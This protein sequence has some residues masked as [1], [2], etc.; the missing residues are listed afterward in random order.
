MAQ[1]AL[2]LA[3]LGVAT[4]LTVVHWSGGTPLCIGSAGCGVV[5]ASSYA[6]L[7]AVP[8]ALLGA[9][10]Y[11]ALG[12]LGI[13]ALFTARLRQTA[14][15]ASFTLA[16][17]G[18]LYSAYLTYVEVAVLRAICL[19]CVVSAG[20]LVALLAVTSVGLVASRAR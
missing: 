5:A 3:G 15:V 19:W 1:V 17:A 14:Y 10:L 2:S 16:L 9:L 11:V 13:A 7:G 12:V 8:V 18:A 6:K 20:L 4:Y